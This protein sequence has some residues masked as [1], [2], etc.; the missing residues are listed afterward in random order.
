MQH[1]FVCS[2]VEGDELLLGDAGVHQHGQ[3]EQIAEGRHGSQ[4]AFGKQF[5]QLFFGS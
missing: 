4:L 3:I 2:A 5:A 1:V